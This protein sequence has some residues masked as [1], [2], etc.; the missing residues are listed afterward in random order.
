IER[1]TRQSALKSLP[2]QVDPI[3]AD[4]HQRLQAVL[5]G[6]PYPLIAINRRE[7]VIALN[8]EARVLAPA[9]RQGASVLLGLRAPEVLD[10]L[11]RYGAP[12]QR[13]RA[14]A[15]RG[16]SSRDR[17]YWAGGAHAGAGRA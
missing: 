4:T 17:D 12:G 3:A 11:R 14:R 6:L 15:R 8:K 2:K 16:A 1:Q 10:V 7:E 9:L 5:G 13:K